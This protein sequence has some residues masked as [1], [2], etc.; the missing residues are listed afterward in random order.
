MR[1]P[2]VLLRLI[3]TVVRDGLHSNW[4]VFIGLLRGRRD[5]LESRFVHIPLELRGRRRWPACA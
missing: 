4:V 1:K 3:G 2:L 5:P